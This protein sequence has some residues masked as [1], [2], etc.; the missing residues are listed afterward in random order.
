[1]IPQKPHL[2][3]VPDV[4]ATKED[5]ITAISNFIINNPPLREAK[6]YNEDQDLLIEVGRE[7]KEHYYLVNVSNLP[8]TGNKYKLTVKW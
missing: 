4:P 1:M 7:F 8:V 2:H 3:S 5:L 6:I